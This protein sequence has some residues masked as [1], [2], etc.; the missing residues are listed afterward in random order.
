VL[1]GVERAYLL[2]ARIFQQKAVRETLIENDVDVFVYGG[3]NQKAGMI[4]I[5]GRQICAATT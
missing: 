4:A 3:S 1:N 5:I 2:D